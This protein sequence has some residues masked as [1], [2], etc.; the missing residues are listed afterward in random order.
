ML[1]IRKIRHHVATVLSYIR[2]RLFLYKFTLESYVI[3]P[4]TMGYNAGMDL[5]NTLDSSI[6]I[7]LACSIWGFSQGLYLHL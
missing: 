2:L 5:M 6:C 1:G 7:R 3:L 4:M